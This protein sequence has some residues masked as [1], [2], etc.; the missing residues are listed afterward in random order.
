MLESRSDE[1][2]DRIVEALHEV[3]VNLESLRVSLA[4]QLETTSDHEARLRSIERWQ[5]NLTPVLAA[6]TFILGV[7]FT[8]VIDHLL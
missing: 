3:N 5:N 1:K 4:G 7:T 2:L 6:I 8:Q